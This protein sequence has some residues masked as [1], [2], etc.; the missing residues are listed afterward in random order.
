M[1]NKEKGFIVIFKIWKCT[2]FDCK[3][4]VQGFM[5]KNIYKELKAII[6]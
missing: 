4:Q 2:Q 1:C 5:H 3:N 6:E